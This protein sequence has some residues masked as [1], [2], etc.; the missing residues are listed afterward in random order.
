MDNFLDNV[1]KEKIDELFAETTANVT[2]FKNTVDKVVNSCS[3]PLDE[4]MN[5]IYNDIINADQPPLNTLERYFL[6]LS[7][8]LYYMGDKLETLGIYDAMSKQAYKEVYNRYYLDA[9]DCKVDTKKKPTV[10]KIT[11][12]AETSS[13]YEGIVN[14]LYSR[15]YKILKN[16]IDAAN[17]ML[18]SISK[19]ISKRMAEMQLTSTTPTGKQILN[20]S[21]LP[22]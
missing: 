6:E 2:Y 8:C 15:A 17:T 10:A 18:S 4:I 22:F 5:N 14:D 11:A 3:A 16:K 21:V 7:N 19:I 12:V 1:D 13:Q 9:G 20:E